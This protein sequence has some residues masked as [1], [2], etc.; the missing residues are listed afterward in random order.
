[1]E[2][3]SN[4]AQEYLRDFDLHHLDVVK[5]KQI[6]IPIVQRLPSIHTNNGTILIPPH[7]PS[8]VHHQI[9]TPPIH[10][11]DEHLF[12]HEGSILGA[13]HQHHHHHS[14]SHHHSM[15][16]YQS[17]SSN[18][19]GEMIAFHPGTP[20]TPPDTP[21]SSRSTD[22]PLHYGIDSQHPQPPNN[23]NCLSK[24]EMDDSAWL[25]QRQQ[26][27]NFPTD[28]NP[29]LA[30]W[31]LLLLLLNKHMQAITKYCLDDNDDCQKTKFRFD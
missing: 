2:A 17:Q 7:A 5:E 13:M 11:G 21:P 10:N 14:H 19:R 23:L 24:P 8:A 27:R 9:L 6:R 28:C 26:F 31:L 4:L 18:S 15:A 1:M 16:L 29:N 3:K 25:F 30:F 22:S 12:S 20:G